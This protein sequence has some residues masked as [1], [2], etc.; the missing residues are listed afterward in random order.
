MKNI[1]DIC[2]IVQARLSSQRVPQ[3]MIKPFCGTTLTDICIQKLLKSKA[4]SR[5]SLYMSVYEEELRDI[6]RKHNVNVFLR[7]EASAKSE[8]TPMTEIFEWWNRL[9]YK[10]VVMVNACCPLLKIET[11]DRFIEAYA[12]SD[13]R[14][15]FGVIEKKN[16]FWNKEGECMTPL[17]ESVMNTKTAGSVYEA[18]HCLYA[19]RMK[20]IGKGIWMGEFKPNDPELFVVE[21]EEIFDI[22]YPWQFR[23]GELLYREFIGKG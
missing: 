10:Y 21:E 4:I 12:N 2:I 1:E 8:G 14:G 18:A 17:I 11:I 15:M 13:S 22:D 5:H 9:P 20:D 19:G 23:T 3:K 16:Y 6:C 7:S